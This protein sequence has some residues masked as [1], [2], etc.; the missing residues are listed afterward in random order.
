M[1][2]AF[3]LNV[4]A[5]LAVSVAA[6]D[7]DSVISCQRHGMRAPASDVRECGRMVAERP[8]WL[9]RIRAEVRRIESVLLVVYA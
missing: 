5:A 7:E 6:P 3:G 9:V 1:L 2:V 4:H 8:D